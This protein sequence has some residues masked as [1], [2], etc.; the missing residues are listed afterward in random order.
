MSNV[1]DVGVIGMGVAGVFCAY[2]LATQHKNMK[3]FGI[4]LGRPQGK[5]RRQIEGW[6]GCLPNSDGKLYQSDI[7]KVA[8]LTG[9]RKA[10]SAST[11]LKHVL[12]EIDT[13]KIVKDKAPSISIDKKLKK[14]GYDVSLNDYIQMYPKEIHALSKY[15]SDSIELNKNV[16]FSFDS[17]VVRVVKQKNMFIIS[18]E[19]KEYHCKKIIVAAGRSGWR[20]T[21]DLYKNFGIIDNND[22]ARFGVRIETNSSIMKDFNRSNCTIRKGDAIEIGPLSWYGTVIPEDHVDMAISAFRGNENRW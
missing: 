12:E 20:W 22:I 14:L 4:D 2:K 9:L 8:A 18:T 6:L 21:N 13:F 5:R 11:Y 19:D 15:L 16:S 17:E 1:F 7:G 3:I 10:K